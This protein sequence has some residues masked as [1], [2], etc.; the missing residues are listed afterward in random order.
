MFE[1]RH[2]IGDSI[3]KRQLISHAFWEN[4]GVSVTV[5]E[6]QR[7]RR[8]MACRAVSRFAQSQWEM[9]LH[10]N[11]V[12]YWLGAND[13]ETEDVPDP[14]LVSEYG[15]CNGCNAI[16]WTKM[17]SFWQLPEKPVTKMSSKWWNFRFNVCMV[18]Y[19]VVHVTDNIIAIELVW[20]LLLMAWCLFG[21]R[22]QAATIMT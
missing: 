21:T 18:L 19:T 15:L 5:L 4:C 2:I 7:M 22:T 13:I 10:S 16:H 12:S 17:S 6:R 14:R 8:R 1:T 3:H 11:A 20:W 9:S